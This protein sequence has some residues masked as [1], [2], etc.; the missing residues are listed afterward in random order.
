MVFS[1]QGKMPVMVEIFCCESRKF[2]HVTARVFDFQPPLRGT[3]LPPLDCDDDAIIVCYR[4]WHEASIHVT[5]AYSWPFWWNDVWNL[6]VLY[7]LYV[8]VA[9]SQKFIL[10]HS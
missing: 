8:G 7:V 2:R 1:S 9:L 10:Q 6:I 5:I 4:Y 3:E